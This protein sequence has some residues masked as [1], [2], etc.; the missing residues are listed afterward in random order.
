MEHINAN[1]INLEN[2][3]TKQLGHIAFATKSTN[4][5]VKYQDLNGI[6]LFDTGYTNYTEAAQ[7]VKSGGTL[8]PVTPEVL[9]TKND[10]LKDFANTPVDNES[11]D[12][13][14]SVITG[15]NM[16]YSNISYFYKENGPSAPNR[17]VNQYYYN[18]KQLKEMLL[19]ANTDATLATQKYI[20]KKLKINN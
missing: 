10:Y 14:Y 3:L 20:L 18:A 16:Q 6:Y 13:N 7:F 15:V 12:T 11:A 2:F 5:Y 17:R 19:Q 9:A 8:T 1:R 4:I